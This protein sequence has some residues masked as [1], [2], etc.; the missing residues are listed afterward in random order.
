MVVQITDQ[1]IQSSKSRIL[2]ANFSFE[3]SDVDYYVHIIKRFNVFLLECFQFSNSLQE[4]AFC[5]LKGAQTICYLF[6]GLSYLFFRLSAPFEVFIGVLEVI[7][8]ISYQINLFGELVAFIGSHADV[9]W[10]LAITHFGTSCVK[11]V[12]DIISGGEQFVD[13]TLLLFQS[14]SYPFQRRDL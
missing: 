12:F 6:D 14:S 1:I 9:H 2:F 8:F 10:N 4:S 5:F 3:V 13:L 7:E 11:Y